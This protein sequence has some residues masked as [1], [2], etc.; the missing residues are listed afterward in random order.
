MKKIM[1]IDF[2]ERRMHR[3]SELAMTVISLIIPL[4]TGFRVRKSVQQQCI[5]RCFLW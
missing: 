4:L 3:H 2:L 5:G 1:I